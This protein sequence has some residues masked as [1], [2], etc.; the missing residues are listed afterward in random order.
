LEERVLSVVEEFY[1]KT[2]TDGTNTSDLGAGDSNSQCGAGRKEVSRLHKR[3]EA[4]FS[5][6]AE[7]G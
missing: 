5:R 4:R 6:A 3:I 1:P 2:G 7:G